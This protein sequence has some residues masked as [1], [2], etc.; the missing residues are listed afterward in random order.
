MTPERKS[1]YSI[2]LA[3]LAVLIGGVTLFVA[4]FRPIDLT[5]TLARSTY[6][7]N[8]LG[9]LPE[10][11]IGLAL[12]ADGPS[13]RSLSVLGV[14]GT[15]TRIEN[16]IAAG[17][18]IGL[19]NSRKFEGLPTFLNGGDV[20]NLHKVLLVSDDSASSQIQRYSYWADELRRVF[21]EETEKIREIEAALRTLYFIDATVANTNREQSIENFFENILEERERR[22]SVDELNEVIAHLLKGKKTEDIQ[23]LVFFKAGT[24]ELELEVIDENDTARATETRRFSIDGV[25]SEV[26]VHRFGA[27]LRFDMRDPADEQ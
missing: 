8:T 10:L 11:Y 12:S 13:S 25:T 15:I 5:T 4:H 21:P 3:L 14:K 7:S 23:Q 2:V 16:G 18:K 22:Q 26:L 17:E 6:I 9:G 19:V 24:Y 20:V 1:N 27:N